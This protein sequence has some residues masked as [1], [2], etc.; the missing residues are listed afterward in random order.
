[1]LF[2][3][4]EFLVFLP[5][6][7]ALYWFVFASSYKAQNLLLLCASYF[8]YGWWDW[9]FLF[10]ILFSTLVNFFIGIFIGKKLIGRKEKKILLWLSILISIGQLCLFKYYNFFV[11]ELI[12][13]LQLVGI[14]LKPTVLDVVLPIGISFYTFQLLSYTVDV[15]KGNIRPTKNFV[16]FA[17]YISFF[18][19]LVAGPI[20]R[21]KDLLP[22]FLAPRS[23]E[24][25][26]AADGCRQILLGVFKKVVIADASAIYVDRI[27]SSPE[28]FSGSTLLLGAMLFVVQIYADFS[29][30]SD[31]A[32]GIAKLFGFKL[33]K[34]FDL[35]YF[36]TSTTELWRRWH[37]TLG[38]WANV[39][40]FTPLAYKLIKKFKDIGLVL[41]FF[42]TFT[43]IGLWHGANYT[44]IMFG[45][46]QGIILSIEF[47]SQKKRKALQHMIGDRIYLVLGWLITMFLWVLACILFRSESLDQFY[48]IITNLFSLSIFTLPDMKPI[49][50]LTLIA[51]LFFTEFMGRKNEH[52][53]DFSEL[54]VVPRWAAY[55]LT[56]Y[57]IIVFGEFNKDT[58]I[59]FQF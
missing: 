6:V 32:I 1:M 50:L 4:F 47:I 55:F 12:E 23:F 14:S 43:L 28:S 16:A 27:F 59:Y 30:Y 52:S 44:F 31:I 9:R 41:S 35:P 38:N 58:F 54:H 20:E 13:T 46:L 42:I 11:L 18:P 53:F 36:S 33:T 29:G 17:G 21:A 22:Q 19:Q 25:S 2:N 56:S 26:L 39:Y 8:F 37:I 45:A 48:L 5:I 15:Y 51:S 10:L 3:S 40:V 7:F 24:Y 49:I 34:N 57:L